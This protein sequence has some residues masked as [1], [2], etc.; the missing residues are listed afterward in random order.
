MTKLAYPDNIMSDILREESHATSLN[1]YNALNRILKELNEDDALTIRLSYEL[2]C[3]YDKI[4]TILGIS[5]DDV[6]NSIDNIINRLSTEEN[7]KLLKD[8][9]VIKRFDNTIK[10]KE[11]TH[12]ES[13]KKK[14]SSINTRLFLYNDYPYNLIYTIKDKVVDNITDDMIEGLNYLLSTLCSQR[15]KAVI[16][17]RFERKMKHKDIAS[18]YGVTVARIT[19]IIADFIRK[20]RYQYN[21]RYIDKGYSTVN[22]TIQNLKKNNPRE[23]FIYDVGFNSM[24]TKNLER[25]KLLTIGDVVEYINDYYKS[26]RSTLM[27]ITNPNSSKN[28][29]YYNNNL[30]GI[31]LRSAK[32]IET[33]LDELG[34]TI[35]RKN[36]K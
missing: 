5:V 7:K 19:P 3:S 6:I 35:E 27:S 36:I 32:E 34:I 8:G 20:C 15:D 24:I 16:F 17:D 22:N 4:S 28:E 18:K 2:G 1:Q 14:K 29:W 25:R 30:R 31:G 12:I 23:L 10:D 21:I 9:I 26:Y 13:H 11:N 33:K